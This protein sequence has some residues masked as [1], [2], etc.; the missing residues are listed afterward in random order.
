MA[1][2]YRVS[3]QKV[4]L[5]QLYLYDSGPRLA[6]AIG[7]LA[8]PAG[9]GAGKAVQMLRGLMAIPEVAP[10]VEHVTPEALNKY[11][12]VPF[13]GVLDRPAVL[14]RLLAAIDDVL[15]GEPIEG[16]DPASG[17]HA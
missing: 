6:V 4:S 2:H 14:D 1:M 11:P 15:T 17:S 16:V 5:F 13:A 10:H 8:A 7:A 3:G 9:P 12:S